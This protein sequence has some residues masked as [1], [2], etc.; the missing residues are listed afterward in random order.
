RYDKRPANGEDHEKSDDNEEAVEHW[1]GNSPS[2]VK[3]MGP[4]PRRHPWQWL[5]STAEFGPITGNCAK[6]RHGAEASS[7][8][9]STREQKEIRQARTVAGC[10][11][12]AA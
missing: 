6:S 3:L 7:R 2:G 4:I 12:V 10:K 8:L 11:P 5:A 9:Y 1:P